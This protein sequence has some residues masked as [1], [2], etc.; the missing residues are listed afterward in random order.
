MGDDE[1]MLLD[2]KLAEVFRQRVA[3]SRDQK[4]AK[5]DADQSALQSA[6]ACRDLCS[7]ATAKRTHA[8]PH[9]ASVRDVEWSATRILS[10]W[11]PRHALCS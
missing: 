8:R 10:S 1:M 11:L 2:D 6:R 7:Q 4:E 9:L 3:A 5:Q